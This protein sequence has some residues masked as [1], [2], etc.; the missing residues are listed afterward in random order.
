MREL[1]MPARQPRSVSQ[2]AYLVVLCGLTAAR[3]ALADNVV[4][5]DHFNGTPLADP[6]PAT[7][8]LKLVLDGGAIQVWYAGV[9]R[10]SAADAFNVAAT[11]HG[12]RWLSY[13]NWQSTYSN[14]EVDGNFVPPAATVTVTPTP[15][16]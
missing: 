6:G 16:T 5:R 10:L 9:L 7:H 3:T 1:H 11:K 13:Y 2:I 4:I 8:R 15:T 14:F 12:F